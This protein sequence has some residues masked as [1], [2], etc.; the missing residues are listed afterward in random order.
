MENP[1]YQAAPLGELD[2]R[3]LAKKRLW[4]V[5]PSPMEILNLDQ[6]RT[7]EKARMDPINQAAPLGE[8]DCRALAKTRLRGCPD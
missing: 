4:G 6:R 8:L 3:A 2:C 7:N 1:I 5:P